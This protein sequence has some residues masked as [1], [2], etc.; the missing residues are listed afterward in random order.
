MSDPE[1]V[2]VVRSGYSRTVYHTHTDCPY[3]PTDP[4]DWR[5]VDRAAVEPHYSE[6]KT[7][8]GVSE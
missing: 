1:P 5:E 4:D 7:C 3:L 2:Y 6:C 8:A